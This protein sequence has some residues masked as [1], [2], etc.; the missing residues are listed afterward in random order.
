MDFHDSDFVAIDQAEGLFDDFLSSLS[1]Q[2]QAAARHYLGVDKA[3]ACVSCFI[4][5]RTRPTGASLRSC[6]SRSLLG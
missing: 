4:S 3:E 6:F 1:L 2:W 5:C